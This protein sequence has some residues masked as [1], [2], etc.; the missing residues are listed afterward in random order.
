MLKKELKSKPKG[1][2]YDRI[3]GGKMNIVS[4]VYYIIEVPKR[5]PS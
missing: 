5:I 4:N 2:V 1:E 3:C